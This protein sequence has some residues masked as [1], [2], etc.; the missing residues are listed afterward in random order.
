MM[1]AAKS[2][3][4]EVQFFRVA[5][6]TTELLRTRSRKVSPPADASIED[7][8]VEARAPVPLSLSVPPTGSYG[9]HVGVPG[10]PRGIVWHVESVRMNHLLQ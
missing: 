8:A 2:R 7:D 5:T 3:P 6:V 1:I 4:S 10:I 9:I